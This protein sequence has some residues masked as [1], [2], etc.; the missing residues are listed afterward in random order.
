M[1]GHARR[2][3]LDLAGWTD[4]AHTGNH[5]DFARDVYADNGGSDLDGPGHDR[6]SRAT[7]HAQH[8][9]RRQQ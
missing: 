3:E 7:E 6:S 1:Y 4:D 5:D 2:A 8:R 9:Y